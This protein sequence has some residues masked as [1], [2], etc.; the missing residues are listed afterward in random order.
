[1][2]RPGDVLVI[3]Q[4]SYIVIFEINK[5]LIL[6][7]RETTKLNLLIYSYKIIEKKIMEGDIQL[8]LKEDID[9][10]KPVYDLSQYTQKQLECFNRRR[11]IINKVEQV[12]GP[13]YLRLRGRGRKIE[14]ENI[15]EE[16]QVKRSTIWRYIRLYLQSGCDIYALIDR[17]GDRKTF[18]Y[19][20][21]QYSKKT[22][23]PYD[24]GTLQYGIVITVNEI[25]WFRE[26]LSWYRTGNVRNL[27]QAYA[28]M[29]EQHYQVTVDTAQ[30]GHIELRPLSEM[31]TMRQFRHFANCILTQ[32]DKQI[33]K[34]SKAE[35]RNDS[36]A[37][38]GDIRS[39]AKGAGDC[40]MIDE[41]EVDCSIRSSVV[42]D[43][44]IGRPI[45]YILICAKTSLVMA[46]SVGLENN[47]FLGLTECLFNL[48][49]DKK[50][51]C[52]EYGISISPEDW[53]HGYKPS[54]IMSDRGAEYIS[55]DGR[56]LL[57]ELGIDHVLLPPR[58]GSLKGAVEKIFDQIE[59]RIAPALEH[60][61][62]ITKRFDSDHNKTAVL[63]MEELN[64]II[65]HVLV[66][67]N[68]TVLINYPY[69]KDMLEKKIAAVP[70]HLWAYE[71]TEGRGPR[72]IA[73]TLNFI[74][75]LL[76]PV[77]ASM[78]RRGLVMKGLVYVCDEDEEFLRMRDSMGNKRVKWQVR[79]DPRD[80]GTLYYLRNGR[81]MRACLSTGFQGNADYAGI[82]LNEWTLIYKELNRK[83]RDGRMRNLQYN[84]L[85]SKII[86][87]IVDR[88]K[89]LRMEENSN[90]AA[91]A[92]KIRPFRAM[93]KEIQKNKDAFYFAIRELLKDETGEEF[94]PLKEISESD[95]EEQ[96]ELN[97]APVI[98]P[99][100]DTD[101]NIEF[102]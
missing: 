12:Y 61:G 25:D 39:F 27:K 35:Y 84:A 79:I 65:L 95:E 74:Y 15:M 1:M 60:N 78:T 102:D 63:I 20:A 93:E 67:H 42:T 70:S 3:C 30:G 96:G 32:K 26:A 89:K 94:D 56:K 68:T 62:L 82:S 6:C 88:A 87:M 81:M 9:K 66:A 83:K 8:R 92:S 72:S 16:Y 85:L 71:C 76:K 33:I 47:S 22:G 53:P 29:L 51:L 58:M 55:D 97:E 13:D 45:L 48:T 4:K 36:R 11:K 49:E 98:V 90:L 50:A 46:F 91:D 17:R 99:Y 28:R 34:T 10:L 2:I 52:A 24:D 18:G 75:S 69:T 44:V 19:G 80:I 73:N 59:K 23:R 37:L 14:L 40:C 77:T 5:N 21:Y 43:K 38:T 64:K 54:R 57:H 7:E 31:P 41:H 86:D 100:D 101:E